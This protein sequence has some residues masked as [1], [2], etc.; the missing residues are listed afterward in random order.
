[1]IT[2][3]WIALLP[4]LVLSGALAALL[5]VV[6][7]WRVH[8]LIAGLTVVTF[9]ATLVAIVV[10]LPAL[11]REV[12]PLF[13]FDRYGAFFHA[14]FAAAGLVTA[15]LSYRYLQ[16]RRGDLEEYYLLLLTATIGAMTMAAAAHFASFQIG[17]A[18]I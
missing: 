10:S 1:M 15:L 17:R 3:D 2:A 8:A 16:R 14:L 12:T 5:L 6:S 11:P 13:R 18:H 9:A 4:L 7:F